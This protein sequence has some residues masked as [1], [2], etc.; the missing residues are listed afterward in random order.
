MQ[1]SVKNKKKEPSKSWGVYDNKDVIHCMPF[2]FEKGIH[3]E[4][5]YAVTSDITH[6]WIVLDLGSLGT[7]KKKRNWHIRGIAKSL[8]LP[9]ENIPTMDDNY[10]D[11]DKL[12][13]KPGETFKSAVSR[14]WIKKEGMIK[15]KDFGVVEVRAVIG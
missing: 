8:E 11:L 12:S 5:F 15:S 6:K 1:F 7:P 9:S 3:S 13:W 2:I 14:L 4:I 10:M